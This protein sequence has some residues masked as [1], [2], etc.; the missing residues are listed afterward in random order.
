[1][2]PSF[3]FHIYIYIYEKRRKEKWKKIWDRFSQGVKDRVAEWDGL[4][5]KW[6][7]RPTAKAWDKSGFED[8]YFDCDRSKKT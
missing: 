6:S 3:Y 1:M 4:S 8:I 5:K 2:L 7:V